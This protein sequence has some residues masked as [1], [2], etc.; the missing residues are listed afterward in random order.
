MII[1]TENKQLEYR[2]DIITHSIADEEKIED[3][4]S[5][6]DTHNHEYNIPV[7]VTEAD[8]A[9]I[10]VDQCYALSVGAIFGLGLMSADI[11]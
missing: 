4:I 9:V 6:K 8:S 7:V 3:T 10:G 5:V 11:I 2:A 1:L